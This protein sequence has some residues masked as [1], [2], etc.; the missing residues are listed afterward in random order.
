[1]SRLLRFNNR[2]LF[3]ANR[4]LVDT[5]MFAYVSFVG[6]IQKVNF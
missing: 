2:E 6:F 5:K 3:T 4:T 1:M